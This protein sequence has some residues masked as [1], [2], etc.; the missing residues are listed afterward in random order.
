MSAHRFLFYQ[1]DIK[2]SDK[3]VGLDGDE[4]RHLS[5]L[6]PR[7][8]EKVYVTNGRGLM[9]S[10][11]VTSLD[12]EAAD[13]QV[14]GVEAEEASDRSITLALALLKQSRFEQA[15]EQCVE[16]GITHCV[17]FVAAKSQVQSFNDAAM[18]RLQR[19][20]VSAMK[21]SFRTVLPSITTPVS[22]DDLLVLCESEP[23]VIVGD[24]DGAS[25]ELHDQDADVIVIVGPEGG[26]ETGELD[27]LDASGALRW[28][29]AP[30]RLRSETAATALVT[31]IVS[32]APRHD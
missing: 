27:R 6:R 12:R 10:C 1:P 23:V 3:T 17:P 24:S 11:I 4:A 29:V 26:L 18:N 14:K 16:L 28:K 8:G 25:P 31:T 7:S 22:F 19:I 2:S 9:L 13:L 30:Y 20:A 5:V 15:L 32:S 21:Q